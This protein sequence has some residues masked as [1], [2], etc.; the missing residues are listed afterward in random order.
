M[1]A[2]AV[3][4]PPAP[5]VPSAPGVP[6]ATR[7]RLADWLELT[8]PRITT[9][10]AITA[11]AGFLLAGSGKP[12]LA[13][14]ALLFWALLGTSLLASGASVLNQV[15]ERQW[16][17]RMRRTAGRPVPSGRVDPDA[18]LA[19]GVGLVV[20]GLLTLLFQVN[21]V[22]AGLGALT[23]AGYVFVYTPMKRWTSLSTV[24]GAVPGAIPPMMGWT[25]ARG[26]LE[27]GAWALFGLLF[28]WQLPHFLAIAWMY[29]DD[30]AR[31]GFP[32]LTVLDPDGRRTAQQMVLWSAALIPV[33]LLPSALDLA[34]PVY[35]A[36]ALALGLG[37][38][39]CALLFARAISVRSARRLL[40]ASVVYL[41]VILGAL[42]V[43]RLA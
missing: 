11:A 38:L 7:A 17:A 13:A 30:Y 4:G 9:M 24:V 25:A 32:M 18:A 26:E 1:S 29:R 37:Y 12:A 8:K 31:G 10:V 22:T 28:F 33:S 39:A 6:P 19:F 3:A 41:P 21:G 23:V 16:D 36:A 34:G 35:F 15:V 2:P 27:L 14:G 42:V 43:D 20:L 40:L 5:G